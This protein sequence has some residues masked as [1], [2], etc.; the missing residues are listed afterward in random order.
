MGFALGR[1]KLFSVAAAVAVEALGEAAVAPK[2][3]SLRG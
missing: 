1:S 2:G 3:F